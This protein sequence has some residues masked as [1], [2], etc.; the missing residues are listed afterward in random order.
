MQNKFYGI[1]LSKS[2]NPDAVNEYREALQKVEDMFV[3]HA[4]EHPFGFGTPNPTMFDINAYP[5]IARAYM[6]KGSVLNNAFEA[7]HFED[8]PKIVAFVE[9]F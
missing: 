7:I 4:N 5:H 9:A 6:L 3:K 2:K 8:F 1:L